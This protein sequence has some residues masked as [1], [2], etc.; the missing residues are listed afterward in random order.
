MGMHNKIRKDKEGKNLNE[1]IDDNASQN[2]SSMDLEM[3]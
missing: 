3:N 1:T 2:F